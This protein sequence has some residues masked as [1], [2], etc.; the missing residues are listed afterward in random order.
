[1]IEKVN[2]LII[3]EINSFTTDV[4]ALSQT[5]IMTTIVSIIIN[6]DDAQTTTATLIL[7]ASR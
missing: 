6:G 7:Q 4:N 1:M 3:K 5:N 2:S